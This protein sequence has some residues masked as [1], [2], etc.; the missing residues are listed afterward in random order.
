MVLLSVETGRYFSLDPVGGRVW[1]LCDGTRTVGDIVE[2]LA[3][4]YE[5][6]RVDLERDV[7]ELLEDLKRE[8]LVGG[9]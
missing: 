6:S 9:L 4:E 7:R 2:V 1:S 5:V 8:R 3:G